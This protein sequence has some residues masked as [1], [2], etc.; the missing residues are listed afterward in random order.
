MAQAPT[1]IGKT[2]ATI[3]P[4]L[5]ACAAQQIDRVFFLTAKTPGRALA[6]DAIETLH[7]APRRAV[8]RCR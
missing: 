4:L 5:K 1:G 3:F 6:L 8:R 7:R 2:L